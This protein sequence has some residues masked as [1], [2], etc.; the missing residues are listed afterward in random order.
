MARSL[1]AGEVFP[2]T[3]PRCHRSQTA[4]HCSQQVVP[5]P[6]SSTHSSQNKTISCNSLITL[7]SIANVNNKTRALGKHQEWNEKLKRNSPQMLTQYMFTKGDLGCSTQMAKAAYWLISGCGVFFWFK[8]NILIA[9]PAVAEKETP[10][11]FVIKAFGEIT[12]SAF[13]SQSETLGS[14]RCDDVKQST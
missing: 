10:R 13:Y 12:V 1:I 7:P 5:P 9:P 14:W 6:L 4:L 8:G 11:T 3:L 2:E